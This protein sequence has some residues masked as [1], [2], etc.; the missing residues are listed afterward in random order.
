MV[1]FILPVAVPAENINGTAYELSAVSGD[2]ISFSPVS[3][4]TEANKPYILVPAADGKMLTDMTEQTLPATPASLSDAVDGAE[5]FGTYAT[6]SVSGVYGLSE[7]KFVGASTGTLRPYRAAISVASEVKAF[8]V[9]LDAGDGGA[10]SID[11]M[12][13]AEKADAQVF[14]LAGQRLT[15]PVRGVNI[16]GGKKVIRK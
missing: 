13:G 15:G 10:T 6:R 14:N 5:F 4:S 2:V 16:V 8:D 1:T 9:L 11:V 7:G 12:A 3:G